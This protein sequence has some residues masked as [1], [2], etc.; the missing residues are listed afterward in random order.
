MSDFDLS[1]VATFD[2]SGVSQGASKVESD[3]ERMTAA[4]YRAYQQSQ[5]S[6]KSTKDQS[7]AERDHARALQSVLGYIEPNYTAQKKLNDAVMNADKLYKSGAISTEQYAKV[8]ELASR[9]TTKGAQSMG[10]MRAGATQL[11]FQIQDITQSLALGVN[12]MTVF[13]QQAGQTSFALSQMGGTVGKVASFLSGPFGS[14]IL[15]ATTILGGFIY[16]LYKAEEQSEKTSDALD[17]Q[18]MTTKELSEAILEL[19]VAAKKSLLTGYAQEKQAYALAAAYVEQAKATREALRAE[20]EFLDAQFS[21]PLGTQTDTQILKDLGRREDLRTKIANNEANLEKLETVKRAEQV[22]ITQR[23]VAAAN[24]EATAATLKYD[25]TL[26]AL[27]E[28]YSN[29]TLT[30]EQYRAG[31]DR[32][33]KGR[34]SDLEQIKEAAKAQKELNKETKAAKVLAD[35]GSPVNGGRISSAFGK[36]SSPGGI[37]SRNHP[38]V[39]YAV[40]V[41]TDVRA[42]QDGI[43]GF[44][45]QAGGYG[46]LIKIDNGGTE[47]RFAH[48]SKLNAQAGQAVKKGDIIGQSGGA[49]GQAGSGTSTGAHLHYEVRV[50]GKPVDP[51]GGKFPFD[52]V[53]VAEAA[54]KAQGALDKFGDRTAESIARI[55]ERFDEQ[56]KLIDQTAR[57]VRE[58]D[59][60]IAELGA[61]KPIGFEQMI[62][63]AE[64]AKIV[65]QDAL[66]KPFNDL[67][68]SSQ[69]RFEIESLIAA[70]REDEAD[71]LSVVHR[72]VDQIGE[73]TNE[74]RQ[75]ILDIVVAEREHAELLERQAEARDAYLSVT[76][77]LADEVKAILGG[78]ADGDILDVLKRQFSQLKGDFL[79]KSLGF[80]A[81]FK[82]LE[83]YVKEETAIESSVD[84]MV[85]ETGRA[86]KSAGDMANELDAAASTIS[87]AARTIS[88]GGASSSSETILNPDFAAMIQGLGEGEP[89]KSAISGEAEKA[90]I[91]T[92]RKMDKSALGLT[93]EQYFE[94]ATK[95]LVS[96]I[97]GSLNELLGANF[98]GALEGA[99]SGAVYGLV[100]GGSVGG[101]LG[102]AKGLLDGLIKSGDIKGAFASGLSDVLGKGLGGAQTGQAVQ[103]IA[104]ALGIGLSKTGSQIGGAVGSFVPIPGGEII[105]SVVGGL[106]GKLFKK[107][108]DGNLGVT[109]VDSRTQAR[110]SKAEVGNNLASLADS[111]TSNIQNIA[112]ALG[113][114]VGSFS[115]S[116]GQRNDYFRVGADANFDAGQKHPTGALYDGTDPDKALA[117][118]L[119]NAIGD[120]AIVG[121]SAAVARA[122]SSSTDIDKAL[123]E[124][125]GVQS[126]E[127]ALAGPSGALSKLFDDFDNLAQE[128]IRLA[129]TYG[130]DLLAVEKLNLDERNALIED[131]IE[132]SVSSLRSLLDDLDFGSLFEG[133]PDERRTKILAEIAD[134][135][136]DVDAGVEGAIDRYADLQRQL[137]ETSREAFGTAGDEYSGDRAAAISNAER[138][139]AAETKRIEDAA[140]LREAERALLATENELTSETNNLLAIQN[141]ILNGILAG[142]ASYAVVGGASGGGTN[143]NEY[144]NSVVYY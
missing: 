8:Q 135:Q 99:F 131:N 83:T 130:L 51:S 133:S 33:T 90:I 78:Y 138:L 126:L 7:A 4:E 25:R 11:G 69:R 67:R 93:P 100:T 113:A 66:L 88:Q 35:F 27:N 123:S 116:L 114:D 64:R 75:D 54:E 136:A 12:P 22:K 120:G 95:T 18:K 38:G 96:P 21:K 108:P 31:L 104:G 32:I 23:E 91:V 50:N 125:L 34:D 28:S 74:Q 60:I 70:G 76:R 80:D 13:G 102:G 2:T 44:S 103:G 68:E 129:R 118:A 1:M 77:S 105:G 140:G 61:R 106:I 58:L 72:L 9:A 65:V 82:E 45:G 143:A 132:N 86:G 87:K 59:G 134:A 79:F 49:P 112:Q 43:V 63:D 73:V 111:L 40:P 30:L 41:G 52:P 101:V 57:S 97:I 92:G 14:I 3:I 109:G 39:D 81:A 119:Q 17:F 117:I 37:G 5:K 141:N 15:A 6:T 47:T 94:R 139:I 26:S 62:E 110:S 29:G 128:R 142:F 84:L 115:V 98:V 53:K 124:A 85:D 16:T 144:R 121:L 107:T 122:L 19:E 46:N 127:Q 36:R 56:P 55:S 71:A 24:D 42:T 48:L 10:Q 20:L 89:G 137:V